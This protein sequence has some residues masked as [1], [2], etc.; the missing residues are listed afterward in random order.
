MKKI[1]HFIALTATALLS[2]CNGT[3]TDNPVAEPDPAW[4]SEC[5]ANSTTAT[6]AVSDWLGVTLQA[7]T[8]VQMA[9]PAS[10]ECVR[11]ALDDDQILS[12]EVNSF[13]GGCQVEW[14]GQPSADTNSV[15][16]DLENPL[17]ASAACGNCLYDSHFQ[18]Q[19]DSNGDRTFSL[20]QQDCYAGGELSRVEWQLP[21]STTPSGTICE[22]ADGWGRR[23]VAYTQNLV[24]KE[25]APC[26][27]ETN[28]CEGDLACISTSGEE[29]NSFTSMCVPRCMV[30]ADCPMTDVV[31]CDDGVCVPRGR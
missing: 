20:V 1:P 23:S 4:V 28:T 3:E 9:L 13:R 21:L 17:C 11:W 5:K 6:L 14:V 8:H 22:F 16:L 2:S 12:V 15:T 24:G 25:F 31:Q 30:D 18:I 29:I 27:E 7:A 19:L 10:F 26:V